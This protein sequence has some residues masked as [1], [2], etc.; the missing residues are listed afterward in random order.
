MMGLPLPFV[1]AAGH[2]W[3]IPSEPGQDRQ[4]VVTHELLQFLQVLRPIQKFCPISN[5]NH[6]F[7]PVPLPDPCAGA[8]L[9]QLHHIQF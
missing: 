8:I 5:E 6:F 3:G 1:G 7:A 4:H 9:A 2:A